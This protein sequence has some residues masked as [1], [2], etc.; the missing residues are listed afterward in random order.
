MSINSR[1]KK[2][3]VL[4]LKESET[5]SGAKKQKWIEKKEIFMAIYQVGQLVS[6]Y[7]FR[8]TETTHQAL[9]HCKLLARKTRIIDD[10][11]KYEVLEVDDKQRLAIISL[12]EVKKW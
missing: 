7:N 11:K 2:V 8:N 6:Y 9:T 4:E 10:N 3:K 1:M 12:K 5:K